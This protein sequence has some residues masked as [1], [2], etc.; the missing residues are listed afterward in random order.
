MPATDLEKRRKAASEKREK[1]RNPLF[2]VSALR[3]SI[4][5]LGRAV[6][7]ALLR[8]IAQKAAGQGLAGG[9]VDMKDV[10]PAKLPQAPAGSRMRVNATKARV[11]RDP[12]PVGVVGA[13]G[14]NGAVRGP[15][16]VCV[17]VVHGKHNKPAS[18][19]PSR[20]EWAGG[21]K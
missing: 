12:A 9:L 1:M 13:E 3:L 19:H 5:N 2:F 16:S 21:D 4:R 20:G 7:D 6:S 15:V 18:R 10:D 14:K 17:R 11:I 8:R